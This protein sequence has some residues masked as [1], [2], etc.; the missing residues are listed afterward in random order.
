MVWCAGVSAARGAYD[1]SF[2]RLPLQTPCQA[3]AARSKLLRLLKARVLQDALGERS[4]QAALTGTARQA[5]D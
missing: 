5:F 4:S 2:P 1:D 3:A